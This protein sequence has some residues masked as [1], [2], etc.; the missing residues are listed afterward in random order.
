MRNVRKFS[1]FLL[2]VAVF[3]VLLYSLFPAALGDMAEN[4]RSG[5][6]QRT[7][8]LAVEGADGVSYALQALQKGGYILYGV[9]S[10]GRISEKK[11]SKGLPEDFEVEHLYVAE[12]GAILLGVYE[13]AGVELTRYALFVAQPGMDFQL[14]LEAPVSGVTADQRRAS[15]GLVFAQTVDS[16]V[17][18]IVLQEGEYLGYTFDPNQSQGL[19]SAGTLEQDAVAK[20]MADQAEAMDAARTAVELAG[21]P[22]TSIAYLASG[23]EGGALALLHEEGQSLLSITKDGTC[24]DLSAGLYRVPWQSGIVMLLL[25]ALVL[26]LSYGFYYLVCEYQKLY[27]PMVIKNL[28]WL[29]LV[30]YVAVAAVMLFAVGPKY[31]AGADENILTGME[32]QV[33]QLAA[34][35]EKDAAAQGVEALDADAL[36][37]AAEALASTDAAYEDCTF[38]LMEQTGEQGMVVAASSGSEAEG[39][40]VQ[41]A[42]VLPGEAARI[43]LVQEK[44][45]RTFQATQGGIGYY[46]AYAPLENGSVLCLRVQDRVLAQGIEANILT[47]ALYAYGAL[48]LLILLSLFAL[49]EVV[50]GAKR[51]TRGID[52]LAAGAPRVRVIHRTG[53]EMEALAAAFNDLSSALEEKRENAALAGSAYLRFVPRRLVALLGASNIE[54]VDKNTCVSHE[55]A[56]MVVRFHFPKAMYQREAKVLFDSI[57]E[58]FAHI[59]G[60]VS[61]AGGT[62][63]NFTHDGFDAVFESG[64]KAA[65]GAAVEVR[66]AL[67]DLNAQ[68]QAR[69][70][71]PVELRV[72]LDHGV[73]MMGV[74]GD[75]DRVVPTVVS[76]CLTTAR[77]LVALA[78]VLDANILCTM[79]VADAAEEYNQ[80]YIGKCKDGDSVIRVYELFDGDPYGMRLAKESVRDSFSNGVY[81]LYSGD[82]SQAKRLFM[83]IA[84]QQGEDGVARYYLYLADRFEKNR[85]DWI[86]LN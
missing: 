50:L 59:A 44:G 15:A 39:E 46:Y 34:Q 73:A 60:P 28:L 57:N 30:G 71:A 27:F 10:E 61:S 40:S 25:V 80:R 81:A 4:L 38:L 83:E 82:F 22:A 41:T 72:A 35:A 43:A 67:L 18:L 17:E 7:F 63:Y 2:F 16:L 42:G 66:Q 52:L 14:L 51:I 84:R 8:I 54:Q 13:R 21:L 3:G 53:D 78:Q 12:N 9:G 33:A 36:S 76:T 75:D 49:G 24:M 77:N 48:A 31:R 26:V 64:S 65:V 85:P 1:V 45:A 11:L 5:E 56:M 58:V 69:G 20:I 37:A 23:A 62:I 86:G 70:D 47:L 55:I 29:G 6:G 19:I 68:R 79:V 32:A 74:V